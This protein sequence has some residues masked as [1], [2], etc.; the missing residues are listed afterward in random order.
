MAINF[1]QKNDIMFCA[2]YKSMRSGQA[3]VVVVLVLGIILTIGISV[4]MRGVTE[5]NVSTTQK[6]STIALE[7]AEAGVEQALGGYVTTTATGTTAN[8]SFD[9]TRTDIAAGQTSYIVPYKLDRGDVATV[10]MT[11][12]TGT[13]VC[14]YWGENNT[15]SGAVEVIL[16]STNGTSYSTGRYGV[17]RDPAVHGN[18]FASPNAHANCT[19]VFPAN[20]TYIS[21]ATDLGMPGGYSPVMLRIRPLYNANPVSIAVSNGTGAAVFP[22]QGSEIYSTGRTADVAQRVKASALN[23]DLP[24]M[25]DAAVFSGGSLVQ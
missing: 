23:T 4:A 12:F 11:G 10:Y 20:K 3:V 6:E 24:F 2:P 15:D 13:N 19:L 9:V 1:A 7:A 25:F 16:Y 8:A 18:G 21:L 17:D 14:V 5:V 22:S